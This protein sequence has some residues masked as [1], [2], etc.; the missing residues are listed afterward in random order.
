MNF[1]SDISA[2]FAELAMVDAIWLG[3]GFFGQAIFFSRWIIQW[4]AS[5]RKAES[6][7]PI[8]FWYLSL[9]GGLIMLAYAVHR[10]DPVFI[11]GQGIASFVYFRN[12]VLIH[13]TR[14]RTADGSTDHF[15]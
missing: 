7:M 3:I 15:L 10:R 9:A 4:V 14:R 1:F 5:E 12:L 11:V 6:R 2:Y 13:K 8:A